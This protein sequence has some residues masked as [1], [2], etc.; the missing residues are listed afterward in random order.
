MVNLSFR[1]YSS[2]APPL[3]PASFLHQAFQ[4][5]VHLDRDR[6]PLARGATWQS[7]V[8][9][10]GSRLVLNFGLQQ[11]DTVCWLSLLQISLWVSWLYLGNFMVIV[12]KKIESGSSIAVNQRLME[13]V[14]LHSMG[15]KRFY[16][17]D[18]ATFLYLMSGA[19]FFHQQ[20]RKN[21]FITNVW[22]MKCFAYIYIFTPYINIYIYISLRFGSCGW[23]RQTPLCGAMCG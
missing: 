10:P 1:F 15:T 8:G 7:L 16:Y 6:A 11:W 23:A 2:I 18:K 12:L 4:R 19:G 5:R 9:K 22:Y 21:V 20:S 3:C 17:W 13:K 14:L